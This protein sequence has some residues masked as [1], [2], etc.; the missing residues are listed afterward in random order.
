MSIKDKIDELCNK[1]NFPNYTLKTSKMTLQQF[2][3]NAL[4][5]GDNGHTMVKAEISMG[6]KAVF[7]AYTKKAG[8]WIMAPSCEQCLDYLQRATEG[9]IE[10][11]ELSPSITICKV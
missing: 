3:D 2:Y 5:I 6:Q 10:D 9:K 8:G 4:S 1:Y 7:A 11:L